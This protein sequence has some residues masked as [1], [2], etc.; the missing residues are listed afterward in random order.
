VCQFIVHENVVHDHP[1]DSGH[2]PE[3]D[4]GLPPDSDPGFVR[5][6]RDGLLWLLRTKCIPDHEQNQQRPKSGCQVDQDRTFLVFDQGDQAGD[7]G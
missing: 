4:P 1:A 7:K 5:L 3:A 2:R 6:G